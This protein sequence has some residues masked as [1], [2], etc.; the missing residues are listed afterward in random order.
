MCRLGERQRERDLLNRRWPRENAACERS[1][2][3]LGGLC[4]PQGRERWL[5][6]KKRSDI[7]RLGQAL[8]S[9]PSFS[10]RFGTFSMQPKMFVF[11]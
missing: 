3:A 1:Y 9:S 4:K 6:I 11:W 8:F 7:K 2:E 5:G 10:G